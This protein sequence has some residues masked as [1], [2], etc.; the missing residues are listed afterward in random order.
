MLRM[1]SVDGEG[2]AEDI[3]D[4]IVVL[5][6]TDVL[7][8]LDMDVDVGEELELEL[9]DEDVGVAMEVEVEVTTT[10]VVEVE[11]AEL[12]ELGSVV[13]GGGTE[14]AVML[15][16]GVVVLTFMIWAMAGT[17]ERRAILRNCMM[18]AGLKFLGISLVC[19]C[20]SGWIRKP[21]IV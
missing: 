17:A 21:A 11:S 20:I 12:V 7:L 13:M 14:V 3:I 18:M 10:T 8:E 19:V 2:G 4:T 16:L 9:E 5:D 6:M 1:I 15:E